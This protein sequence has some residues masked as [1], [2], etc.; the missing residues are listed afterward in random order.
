MS[1]TPFT[2]ATDGDVEEQRYWPL[3]VRKHFPSYEAFW[4]ERVAP[5]TNRIHYR[6]DV[7][8]RGTTELARDGFT[9]EDVAIAQLHY[10]LLLHL[11]R[12]FDL[13][14]A[15]R[16]FDHRSVIANRPFDRHAFFESFTRLSGASDIADELLARRTLPGRYDPWSETDGRDART[17]W[18][19]GQPDPLR[20]IRAYRNR[21]VHGR[22][23]PEYWPSVQNQAARLASS[24]RSTVSSATSRHST[25]RAERPRS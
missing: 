4:V 17:A 14:H 24:A 10:T 9:D 7:S 20:P 18:R 1:D 6:L 13:L 16:A 11:G 12:V 8:F 23:V 19:K 21:L 22:V 15:A 3:V 2:I 5:L 25:T